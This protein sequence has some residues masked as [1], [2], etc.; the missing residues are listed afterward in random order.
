MITTR[1]RWN[2]VK[3]SPLVPRDPPRGW[4]MKMLHSVA[5]KG[6]EALDKSL[7]KIPAPCETRTFQPS[8]TFGAR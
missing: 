7:D 5:R 1:N 4:V 6:G 8:F 2:I 3:P